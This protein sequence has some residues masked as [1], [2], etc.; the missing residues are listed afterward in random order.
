MTQTERTGH[1]PLQRLLGIFYLDDLDNPPADGSATVQGDVREDFKGP[2][3]SMEGGLVA[4][5]IDT[6]GATA[7]ARA[8]DG[9]VATQSMTIAFLSPVR[10]GPA[11]ARGVPVRVGKR[12]AV[13]E[14]HLTDAGN[15]DRLCAT[16]LLTVV[17]IGD[18][19]SLGA[20]GLASP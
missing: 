14:V 20:D 2:A 10:V 18:R 5:L 13:V 7:A 4:T 8:L 19:P 12:D 16:A 17:R 1:T 6:A 11:V 15:G 3:G 9:M